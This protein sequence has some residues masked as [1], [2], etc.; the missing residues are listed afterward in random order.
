MLCSSVIH[1]CVYVGHVF[2]LCVCVCKECMYVVLCYV[3]FRVMYE[4][5]FCILYVMYVRLGARVM[6]VCCVMCVCAFM[7]VTCMKSYACMLGMYVVYVRYVSMVC[8]YAFVRY[9]IMYVTY[10]CHVC[11]VCI[12]VGLCVYACYVYMYVM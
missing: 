5:I 6:C 9:V 7:Y 12:Y 11:R 3:M 4:C 8:I 1:V 10:G 2:T